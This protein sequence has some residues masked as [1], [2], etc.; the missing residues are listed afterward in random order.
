MSIKLSTLK[1]IRYLVEANA[2]FGVNQSGSLAYNTM[3]HLADST[4]ALEQEMLNNDIQQQIIDGMAPSIVGRKRCSLSVKSYLYGAPTVL[5]GTATPASFELADFLG[6]S[7]GGHFAQS[8]STQSGAGS[9]SGSFAPQ[10]PGCFPNG[11]IVGMLNSS[12]KL[13]ARKVL[14]GTTTKTVHTH[15]SFIP[16]NGQS[17]YNSHTCYLAENCSGTLQFYTKGH[18]SD[19]VWVAVGCNGGFS[20]ENVL[21][22]IPKITFDLKGASWFSGSAGSLLPKETYV[23][24]SHN[25]VPVFKDSK[26]FLYPTTGGTTT[27]VEIKARSLVLKPAITYA[28]V[29]TPGGVENIAEKVRTRNAAGVLSIELSTYFEDRSYYSAWQN[30]TEYGMLVQ[31]GSAPGRTVVFSIPRVQ[32]VN[33]VRNDAGGLAG[34]TLSLKCLDDNL[35]TA[36]SGFSELA[37]SVFTISFL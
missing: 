18:T 30:G 32:I 20:L 11:T 16:S 29:E 13:E 26:V 8:G 27:G 15:F 25:A 21:G 3:R 19:D 37:Q 9:S 34:Q 36:T 22:Q 23:S 12:G 4:I 35:T 24:A 1:H 10:S 6:V 33:V 7:M 14:A 31:I 2:N 28:D 17:I 5:S